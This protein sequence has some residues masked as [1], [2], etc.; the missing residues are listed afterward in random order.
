MMRI[1]GPSPHADRHCADPPN[2]LHTPCNPP[3]TR[4][5]DHLV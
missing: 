5:G 2:I 3:L 4:A 1:A